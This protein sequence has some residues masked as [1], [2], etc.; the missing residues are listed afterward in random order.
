MTGGV[1]VRD[2]SMAQEVA[3]LAESIL[4]EHADPAVGG[5]DLPAWKMLSDSGLTDLLAPEEVGGAGAGWAEV[6][7]VLGEV[8]AAA[9]RLPILEHDVLSGWLLDCAGLPRRDGEVRTAGLFAD[10]VSGWVDF[11]GQADRIVVLRATDDHQW[12][13]G[14][15]DGEAGASTDADRDGHTR[16]R[17]TPGTEERVVAPE[18]AE[19]Y[20]L[21]VALSRAAM[22]VGSSRRIV[23]LT[24]EH[25][26]SREQFGRTLAK[27]QGVQHLVS[28][29]AAEASLIQA[30]V[31]GAIGVV[32]GL[33]LRDPHVRLAVLSAASCAAHGAAVV[34]RNAHQVLGAMGYTLEHPLHRYTNRILTWRSEAYSVRDLDLAVLRAATASDVAELW[35]LLV[36]AT[37]AQ[38]RGAP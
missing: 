13:V 36:D 18:V 20:R 25:V 9:A 33:S 8:G 34:A 10:G 11:A 5:I 37:P 14:V 30:A 2:T 23:E 17:W 35:S 7:A 15:L 16:V 19:E 26:T 6:G 3:A 31:D 24:V 12:A 1:Q 21:R 27:F 32:G 38:E 22:I 29:T 4:E 28:A